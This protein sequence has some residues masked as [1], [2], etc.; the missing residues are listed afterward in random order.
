MRGGKGDLLLEVSK[1]ATEFDM[2]M[3]V[4]LSLGML[5]VPYHVDREADYNA[6]YLAPIEGNLV[7]SC[8]WECR[9]FTEVWMDGAR[10]KG[11]EGQL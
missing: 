10:G 9:K 8:L 1:A 7:K 2:D 5:T 6:Y 3:G 4:Y 11:P